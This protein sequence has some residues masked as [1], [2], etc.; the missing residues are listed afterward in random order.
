MDAKR[1]AAICIAA[2]AMCGC[3]DNSGDAD[4]KPEKPG[5]EVVEPT[6]KLLDFESKSGCAIDADCAAGLFCFRGA[7]AKECDAATA[8]KVGTCDAN[9][10]CIKDN[11]AKTRALAT[12]TAVVADVV[13]TAEVLM[14]PKSLIY[15]PLRADTVEAELVLA[16]HVGT[17][18]YRVDDGAG[19]AQVAKYAEPVEREEEVGSE[20]YKA[21]V[22]KFVLPTTKS[23]LGSK[24]DIDA[25]TIVSSAGSWSV[26]LAPMQEIGG[27]FEGYMNADVIGGAAVPL[28]MA[29]DVKPQTA[30]KYDDVTSIDLYL[31]VSQNDLL[32]PEN[33]E[34]GKTRWAK[35]AMKK[36]SGSNCHSTDGKCFEAVFGTN[37]YVVDGSEIVRSDL[38]IN[39]SIRVELSAFDATYGQW[40]GYARDIIQGLYRVQNAQ[41]E[42]EWNNAIVEGRIVMHHA[43]AKDWNDASVKTDHKAETSVT[44][45]I[46][47]LAAPR[48]TLTDAKALF[49]AQAAECHVT[50]VSKLNEL[51]KSCV[52]AATKSVIEAAHA[53]AGKARLT[54][55]IITDFLSS[56]DNAGLSEKTGYESFDKFLEACAKG[57]EVCME[58]PEFVCGADLLAHLYIAD[59]KAAAEDKLTD[60][61]KLAAFDTW[62][63]LMRESYVGKQFAAYRNDIEIRK[64][65]LENADAPRIASAALESFNEGLLQDWD[66]TV[67]TAHLNVVK[68]QFGQAAMEMFTLPVANDDI[69]SRRDAILSEYA[70]AHQGASDALG[71]ATRR[72]NALYTETAKRTTAA[73]S[74]RPNLLDLYMV[75][76]I[77]TSVNKATS[78]ESLN[79]AYGTGIASTL[80]DLNSLD[81]SF[82]SLVF[83]RDAEVAVSTSVDGTNDVTKLLAE[84]KAA[85]NKTVSQASDKKT[86]IF[87][88][89][90][91]RRFDQAS[92]Q[93]TLKA[94]VENLKGEMAE[95]CGLPAKCK[96]FDTCEKIVVEPFKCGLS[97]DENGNIGDIESTDASIGAAGAAILAYREATKDLET[98]EAEKQALDQKI[99]VAKSVTNAYAEKI[100]KLNK[101][102]KDAREAYKK[103]LAQIKENENKI[104]DEEMELLKKECEAQEK[105]FQ[106]QEAQMKNWDTLAQAGLDGDTSL[107]NQIRGLTISS[108]SLEFAGDTSMAVAEAAAAYFD[109]AKGFM[110]SEEAAAA[111]RGGI[112]TAGTAA[113]IAANAAKLGVDIAAT[114]KATKLENDQAKREFEIEKLD[115]QTDFDIAK[116]ENEIAK[117][118]NAL[119]QMRLKLGDENEKLQQQIDTIQA[120]RE[121]AEIYD[122]DVMAL[123]DRR[124]ELLKL[125]ADLIVKTAAIEKAKIAR[126]RKLV[127]YFSLVQKAQILEAQY[128]AANARLS[129]IASIY[130]SP[131]QVFSNASD[132]EVVESKIELAKER[133]YDYLAVVEYLGVRPFVDLRRAIYLAKS[134][135]DLDG[136]VDRIE[137]LAS[138][139]GAPSTQSK[140]ELSVRELMGINEDFA[141]M[142]KAQRF[143]AVMAKGNIPVN[144]LTRYTV[145]TTVAD[146][147]Q[148]SDLRA[149]TFDIKIRDAL[150]LAATCN[151][152]IKSISVKLVGDNLSKDGTIVNPTL[153]IFYNGQ[154]TLTSCQP[155]IADIVSVL[156]NKTTYGKQSV[157]YVQ[158]K[159]VSP[160]AGLNAYAEANQT[161]SGYPFATSYT[162]LI[163]PTI[164]ENAKVNWDNVDDIMIEFEYTYQDLFSNDSACTK[165]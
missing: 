122:R 149:A 107:R 54:S 57:E 95:I 70:D 126:Q 157:F 101:D 90:E 25:L 136:I 8:C 152:K 118:Q 49:D 26:Q 104:S 62:A 4:E 60:E 17:L 130:S 2:I 77:E 134:P 37:G 131:A 9:G 144:A 46:A 39:R 100:E 109:D 5:G 147:L 29:L 102:R 73:A 98:A 64:R 85:A 21:Y 87:E 28:R 75:A 56:T 55:D 160:R 129:S 83:M 38:Q 128:N 7:C 164:G 121:I 125:E 108:M 34:K 48:C 50:D 58:R 59:A 81:R 115:R 80:N 6:P 113:Q 162:V 94:N 132:L 163:D 133:V 114:A 42:K 74:I 52:L 156:G 105:V 112:I 155:N 14:A 22:Y 27:Y 88:K 10:R 69:Q 159:K 61:E 124:G 76:A 127:E 96:S 123:E 84:R 97:V 67:L 53:A 33:A 111:V 11:K 165:A 12:M 16:N 99:A 139:C 15:V 142:T 154:T 140:V 32:S 143:R 89:L 120:D 47:S 141:T 103:L 30:T 138:E 18:M 91:S 86:A 117:L 66:A 161:L 65:W 71:L 106:A 20:K 119:E 137:T 153:T 23:S 151:G 24:G 148:K 3:S 40:T 93:A 35:V 44:R 1:W 78:N 150:N 92:I 45:D 145:D 31:P 19:T 51:S 116:S 43:M 135:N 36:S 79:A 41:G 63:T 82:D 13:P 68:S 72:Y 146:L 110:A 158:D